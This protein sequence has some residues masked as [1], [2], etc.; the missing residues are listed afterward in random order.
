MND[1]KDEKDDKDLD[2]VSPAEG[3]GWV[4]EMTPFEIELLVTLARKIQRRYP[5]GL[6][7]WTPPEVEAITD[8]MIDTYPDA[9]VIDDIIGLAFTTAGLAR[10]WERSPA[11]IRRLAKT[12]KLLALKTASGAYVYPDFQIDSHGDVVAGLFE[13]INALGDTIADPWDVARWLATAPTQPSPIQL[14]RTGNL[15]VALARAEQFISRL[16]TTEPPSA[17]PNQ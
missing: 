1:D 3:A 8:M 7:T 15:A 2:Q 5:H 10:Y 11:S 4:R 16:R 9:G 17:S 6:P 14:L 13:V 12:G